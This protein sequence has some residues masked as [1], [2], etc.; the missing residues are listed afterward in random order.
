MDH[1]RCYSKFLKGYILVKNY[2][3][4]EK[5]RNVNIQWKEHEDINKESDLEKKEKVQSTNLLTKTF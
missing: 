5:I 1:Y 2:Y 4:D 3:I